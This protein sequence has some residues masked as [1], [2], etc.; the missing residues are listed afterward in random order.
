M[1]KYAGGTD[2]DAEGEVTE[3]LRSN[4]KEYLDRIS[5]GM[6]SGAVTGGNDLI[7]KTDNFNVL[8]SRTTECRIEELIFDMDDEASPVIRLKPY[9]L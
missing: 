5:E 4:A 8:V 9:G 2:C 3:N 1:M 7:S 6:A